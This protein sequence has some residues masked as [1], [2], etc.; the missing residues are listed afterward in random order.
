MSFAHK[1][2]SAPPQD[3]TAGG[4]SNLGADKFSSGSQFP[5]LGGLGRGMIVHLEFLSS[6]DCLASG[7]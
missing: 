7:E 6:R 2:A 3:V 4:Q 5:S 1:S